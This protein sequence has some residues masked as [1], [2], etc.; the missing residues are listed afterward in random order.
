M[1]KNSYFK[2]L[3]NLQLHQKALAKGQ[4]I[5]T[6]QS[7]LVEILAENV[8]RKAYLEFNS[9]LVGYLEAELQMPRATA[10]HYSQAAYLAQS[11]P[12]VIEQIADG[13]LSV[14][15]VS[16]V[17]RAVREREKPGRKK[18]T[19][20]QQRPLLEEKAP[21][22]NAAKVGKKETRMLL[23]AVAGKTQAQ[24]AREIAS[25]MG[26]TST[27]RPTS[28]RVPEGRKLTRLEITLTNEELE[29]WDRMLDLM[30]HRESDPKGVLM[31]AVEDWLE[32]NDPVRREERIAKKLKKKKKQAEAAE[33]RLKARTS[34]LA[35]TAESTPSGKA[36]TA[37]Q[38]HSQL[39]NVKQ[40]TSNQDPISAPTQRKVFV[41]D[42]GA[43]QYEVCGGTGVCGETRGV[44]IDHIVPRSQG[45]S[46][47]IENLRVLCRAHNRNR[48]WIERDDER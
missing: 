26:G 48:H 5:R 10:Y 45:G 14:Y 47:D 43:C 17:A 6:E 19:D 32:K 29:L 2:S 3:N 42:K 21:K 18:R 46:N 44:D 1:Q 16:Q 39:F 36:V 23:Q 27:P 37:T 28:R 30:A 38:S 9:S 34:D 22:P 20:T 8:R 40:F 12:E 33:V 7:G 41:R 35:E 31:R 11:N 25:R 13:K 24:A 4:R 15:V